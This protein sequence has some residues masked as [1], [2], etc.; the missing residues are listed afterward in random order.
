MLKDASQTLRGRNVP[1]SLLVGL[2]IGTHR[3][4]F[5]P[6]KNICAL[7]ANICTSGQK[8]LISRQP[9]ILLSSQKLVWISTLTLYLNILASGHW[10][11]QWRIFLGV[12]ISFVFNFP[13]A[14]TWSKIIV[15]S[16]LYF[17]Q[18]RLHIAACNND[19]KANYCQ[20]TNP[21]CMFCS[22][23]SIKGSF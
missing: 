2:K 21:T 17:K 4:H 8:T 5:S 7:E 12:M 18:Q 20:C 23:I 9:Y 13:L 11:K 14:D 15:A 1:F 10:W 3:A 16:G 22:L 19:L 6:S